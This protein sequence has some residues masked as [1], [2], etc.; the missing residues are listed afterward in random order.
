[1]KE[2]GKEY[3]KFILFKVFYTLIA[4]LESLRLTAS[5]I[6]PIKLNPRAAVLEEFIPVFGNDFTFLASTLA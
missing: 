4:Y 2:K 1:M 5:P 6:N 3:G